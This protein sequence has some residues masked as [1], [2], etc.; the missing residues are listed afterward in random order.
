MNGAASFTDLTLNKVGTGYTFTASSDSLT[1]ATSNSFDVTDRLVVTVQ[2]PSTITA[3]AAF[4]LVVEAEDG[5][6]NVDTSYNGSVTVTDWQT[7]GG[8]TTVTAAGG[9]ATFSDLT[10][11]QADSGEYLEVSADGLALPS[12][13]TIFP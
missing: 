3:G 11:T 13:P 7:L 9:V 1:A 8:T 10:L 12:T 6:G 5:D 4:S 2:P